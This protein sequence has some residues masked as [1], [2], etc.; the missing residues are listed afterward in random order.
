MTKTE[1]FLKKFNIYIYIRVIGGFSWLG[2][3]Q[4]YLTQRARFGLN[5]RRIIDRKKKTG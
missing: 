2:I 4:A 5:A 3:E 1:F